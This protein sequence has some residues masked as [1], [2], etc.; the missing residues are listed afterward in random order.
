[1]PIRI[2][3]KS[4][5]AYIIY[6]AACVF[7][8]GAASGVPLSLGLYFSLL[9][10][11]GNAVASPVL[12]AACSAV[13]ADLTASLCA[14]AEA[15]FLLA[16]VLIYRRTG[17]KM[18]FEAAVWCA[19]AL[20]PFVAL[21]DRTLPVLEDLSPYAVRAIAAAA[22][23]LFFVFC[24]KSVYACVFRLGRCRLKEDEIFC[25]AAVYA[26]I[27]TGFINLAGEFAYMALCAFALSLSARFFRGPAS[28]IVAIAAGIPLAVTG[29][30]LT[31]VTLCVC[32][33]ALSLLFVRAGRAAPPVCV[34]AL[35]CAY[36]Y[37]INW[38]SQGAALAAVCAVAICI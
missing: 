24:Y 26:G 10:C 21:S 22:V 19:I 16:V 1:M 25:L 13:H 20:A 15:A 35:M 32:A 31:P 37:T 29:L 34:C 8:N 7:L 23:L 33:G 2:N 6:A 14:L 11:G 30:S 9:I 28:L 17:K 36:G 4:V 12:Y 5:F 3:V 38:F 18:R 27:G